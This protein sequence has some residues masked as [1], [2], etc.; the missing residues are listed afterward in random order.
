MVYFTNQEC[1]VSNDYQT[2]NL[3]YHKECPAM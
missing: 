1:H 2:Q 3:I